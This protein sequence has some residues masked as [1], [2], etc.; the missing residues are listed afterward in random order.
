MKEAV[1]TLLDPTGKSAY[2]IA[3]GTPGYM[4]SERLPGDR[5]FLVTFT[6]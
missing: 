4:A 6:A 3:L 5:S 2:S 1:A